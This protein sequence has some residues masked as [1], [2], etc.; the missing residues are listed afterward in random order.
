MIS[1]RSW[2]T[3]DWSSGCWRLDSNKIINKYVKCIFKKSLVAFLQMQIIKEKM[4][5]S[6]VVPPEVWGKTVV[7]KYSR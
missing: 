4:Q 6:A 2:D 1:E 7:K 5:I 3:E